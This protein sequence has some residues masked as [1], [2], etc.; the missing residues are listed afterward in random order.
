M[1]LIIICFSFIFLYGFDSFE[2]NYYKLSPEE[3]REIFF[4]KMNEMFDNSFENILKEREFAQNFINEGAKT[5]FRNLDING[6]KKL[7]E[8]KNK[9]RINNLFNLDEYEKK[10]NLIPKSMGI[11]Q[12]LVESATAT[13]RFAR[14]AN[15][16]FGEWTWGEKGLIPNERQE[17]KKHKIR[18]FDSLQESVDSYILNLNRHFAYEDFRSL[19]QS[20]FI[21][22]KNITGIKAIE[23]L[24][25][26]SEN[27]NAYIEIIKKIIEKYEL[28]KYDTLKTQSPFIKR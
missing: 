25:S 3:Q 21:Q 5:G 14:E 10:I 26:Y 6:L 9:Y 18:I 24:H 19:R 28:E 16:L 1:K 2:K 4:N 12:A 15:N 22:G 20:C 8:L 27:K 11:A 7:I 17:G 23:N 13:S